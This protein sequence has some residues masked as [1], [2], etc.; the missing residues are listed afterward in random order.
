[1]TDAVLVWRYLTFPDYNDVVDDPGVNTTRLAYRV[2]RLPAGPHPEGFEVLVPAWFGAVQPDSDTLIFQQSL[3]SRPVTWNTEVSV[4]EYLGGG[5]VGNVSEI[6]L[7]LGLS[8]DGFVY[9]SD[10]PTELAA[11]IAD[12]G[13]VGTGYTTSEWYQILAAAA[14]PTSFSYNLI[15]SPR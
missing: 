5:T 13:N 14:P 2:V 1:M 4:F 11:L 3:V 15:V 8:Q 6:P 7:N 9:L 12:N 10:D